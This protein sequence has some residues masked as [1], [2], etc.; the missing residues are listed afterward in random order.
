MPKPKLLQ[1]VDCVLLRFVFELL[2]ADWLPPPT[3]V[4]PP[5][6]WPMFWFVLAV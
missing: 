4:P 6:F 2:P 1:F 5:L 3:V